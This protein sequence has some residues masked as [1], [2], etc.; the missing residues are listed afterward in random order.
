M[1][2]AMEDIVDSIESLLESA[3]DYG[4]TSYELVKL[5]TI[6]KTSDVVSSLIPHAV[7]FLVLTSFLLFLNLGVAFW[8]GEIFGNMFYGF[9]V[10]ASFYGIIGLVL[11]FF[12]HDRIKKKISDY[13]VKQALK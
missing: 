1:P 8:L 6:N 3:A 13:I 2:E 10:V 12:M 9:F 11:H 7:V 5:K 4:K